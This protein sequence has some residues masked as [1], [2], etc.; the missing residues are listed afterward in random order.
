MSRM[1]QA[2]GPRG[3]PQLPQA[4]TEAGE[5]A[6]PLPAIAKTESCCVSFLLWHFGHA[7]LPL[8]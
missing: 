8:P 4:P 2:P 5:L 3:S 7:A 6:E 1:E